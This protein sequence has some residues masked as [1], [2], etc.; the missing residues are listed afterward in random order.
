MSSGS[1]RSKGA[2]ARFHRSRNRRQA[3]AVLVAIGLIFVLLP[4][5][6]SSE[7][8]TPGILITKDSAQTHR[9]LEAFDA[10]SMAAVDLDGDGV[11]EILAHNDNNNFY[12]FNGASGALIAELETNH[13]DGWGARVL[14]GPAV[15]DLTGNGLYDIVLTNSAGWITVFEVQ[16]TTGAQKMHFEKQWEYLLDPHNENPDYADEMAYGSWGGHPGLDGPTFLADAS[17]DGRDEIFVQLDD[18]PGLYKLT[19]DGQV[20]W[21]SHSSDGN[22][23]PLVADLTGNGDLEA[24][25]PSDGGRLHIY[26]AHTMQHRCSFSAQ[27]HGA[28]PASISVSP[29]VADLTGDGRQEIVFGARNVHHDQSDPD[30]I[31]KSN[32]HH[33]AVRHDCSVLWQRS[34]DW[35]NPHVHMHPAPVDITGNGRF[36]VI[37]QDWN[38][39]GHKPGNWEHTGAGNVYALQGDTGALLWRYEAQTSWSNNNLAVADVTEDGAPEILVN[40]YV[41]GQDGYS[42]LSLTGHR[43]GFIESPSGWQVT[44]GPLVADLNGD[45]RLDIIMPLHRGADFCDQPKDIGCREGALQIY[46]TKSSATPLYGNNHRLNAQVSGQPSDPGTPG[47]FEPGFTNLRGN[48]WWVET[49]VTDP[50]VTKVDARVNGGP[51]IA[52]QA[53]DWGSWAESLH[54]RQNSI[55]QLRAVAD[56]GSTGLSD[57][58][59]WTEATRTSCPDADPGEG[60]GEDPEPPGDGSVEFTNVRGNA[61][62]VETEASADRTIT[63]V[64]ARIDEGAWQSLEATGWGSWAKSIHAPQ[65]SLVEFRATFADGSSDRSGCYRWTQAEPMSCP[66]DGSGSDPFEAQFMGVRGNAWWVETEVEADRSL[67]AVHARVDQGSWQSLSETDWGSWAASLH[68]SKG[69]DVVFRASAGDG[70]M[71]HSSSYSWPP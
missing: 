45:G 52:L 2:Y 30:W 9:P 64:A 6:L 13:P 15:G 37:F 22:S 68:A 49:E 62:W 14:S 66:S 43:T 63:G 8:I 50:R 36:D 70:S 55:V 1:P 12:V 5:G 61:W 27:S 10:V 41:G 59:Q 23:G 38:T 69:S 16:P 20:D 11:K 56:D 3:W 71:V 65:E 58:Y 60:P 31:D 19:P 47:A 25:Y 67:V 33:F 57:C 48:E 54:A 32:A 53:T 7:D 34:F 21:W 46:H 17:G 4:T 28:W 39:V 51:W 35:N 29:S 18:M 26:D 40:E 42:L 44:K 24:I